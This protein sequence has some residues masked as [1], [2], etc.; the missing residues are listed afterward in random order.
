MPNPFEWSSI[1]GEIF[2]ACVDKKIYEDP[3]TDWGEETLW[4]G[5]PFDVIRGQ[6]LEEGLGGAGA[7]RPFS[8]AASFLHRG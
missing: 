6:V 4:L 8:E 1:M 7:R 2:S 3:R 5:C